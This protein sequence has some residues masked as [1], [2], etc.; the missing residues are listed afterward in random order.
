MTQPLLNLSG[1]DSN[2]AVASLSK[3]S[4]RVLLEKVYS[5][6]HCSEIDTSDAKSRSI[7]LI[8]HPGWVRFYAG[9]DRFG[10]NLLT[11]SL[12]HRLKEHINELKDNLK[13]EGIATAQIESRAKLLEIGLNHMPEILV[14]ECR[15]EEALALARLNHATVLVTL[16][17]SLDEECIQLSSRG[18]RL[19]FNSFIKDTL[20]T[21][22]NLYV[23]PTEVDSGV[24][25]GG[26]RFIDKFDELEHAESLTRGLFTANWKQV[27]LCGGFASGCLQDTAKYFGLGYRYLACGK[28]EIKKKLVSCNKLQFARPPLIEDK[29]LSEKQKIEIA[30]NF[31]SLCLYKMT[32]PM[33]FILR[34]T[35]ESKLQ[36]FFW[37]E[38]AR[39]AL[40]STWLDY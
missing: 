25:L 36:G 5:L 15:T 11:D 34:A 4:Q 38:P 31:M 18:N 17:A 14:S 10:I 16:Q 23:L 28:R 1:L 32:E 3:G 37:E 9:Y 13:R 2:Q 40:G 39:T 6:P 29:K 8:S 7:F 26:N 22:P 20:G 19:F 24:I 33:A 30:S 12:P 35:L 21:T 27:L